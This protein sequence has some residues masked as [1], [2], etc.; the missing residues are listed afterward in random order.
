MSGAQGAA[1]SGD[2]G[3]ELFHAACIGN[4]DAI[5]QVMSSGYCDVD[6]TDKSGRTALHW[7]VER[8]HEGVVEVLVTHYHA[9]VDILSF[10]SESPLMLAV[11]VNRLGL[12]KQLLSYGAQT[13]HT[14]RE[15]ASALHMAAGLGLSDIVLELVNQG[16]WVE[17]EDAEG[18]SPLFYA[19]RESQLPVVRFLLE[20]GASAAHPNNDQE[21]PL[22][23]A[24][25]CCNPQDPTSS[26]I[27]QLL[28]TH[29]APAPQRQNLLEPFTRVESRS[30]GSSSGNL[31]GFLTK[32]I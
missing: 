20:A 22:S 3:R 9:S 21:T 26:A 15:G 19:I 23:L 12:V 29:T 6:Q 17:L 18:E 24:R 13:Q 5:H 28:S 11:A 10:E 2:G 8:G 31:C 16:A 25:E 1:V 4:V 7:A 32:T 27:L 30:F 14:N